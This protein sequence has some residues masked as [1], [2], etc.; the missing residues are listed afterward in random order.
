MSSGGSDICIHFLSFFLKGVKGK[1][2]R[3]VLRSSGKQVQDEGL[4]GGYKEAV[5]SE[6]DCGALNRFEEHADKTGRKKACLTM[7]PGP[8]PGSKRQSEIKAE[9]GE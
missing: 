5:C 8:M 4:S 1:K 3:V 6:R 2:G 7:T 9:G